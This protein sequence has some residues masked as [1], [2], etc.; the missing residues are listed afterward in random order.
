MPRSQALCE[1]KAEAKS[2]P[3]AQPGHHRACPVEAPRFQL[4]M[5]AR[6]GHAYSR[7]TGGSGT[8][9][10]GAEPGLAMAPP[11]CLS[12]TAP[13][14][15]H[16]VSRPQGGPFLGMILIYTQQLS[17]QI[18]GCSSLGC[19]LVSNPTG[20]SG[21]GTHPLLHPSLSTRPKRVVFSALW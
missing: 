2:T 16:W 3:A 7:Q 17:L 5:T 15:S 4:T 11:L 14:L 10:S 9:H 21:W 1:G 12:F 13:C 6:A 19:P 20:P 8:P 18:T